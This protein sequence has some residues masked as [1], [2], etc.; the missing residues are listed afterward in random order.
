MTAR[1]RPGPEEPMP[2]KGRSCGPM[3]R[4]KLVR[5]IR[6]VIQNLE[7]VSVSDGALGVEYALRHA[8]R[9][10]HRAMGEVEGHEDAPMAAEP[11]KGKWK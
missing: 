9:A 7:Y 3:N 4:A 11:W 5:H 2:D 10:E 6:G 8:R 1:L